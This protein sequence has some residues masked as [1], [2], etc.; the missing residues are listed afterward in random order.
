[1]KDLNNIIKENLQRRVKINENF[2]K[3][4]LEE[5]Q[6]KRFD[7][8]MEYL[9]DLVNEGFDESQFE[10][11]INE[12]FEWFKNMFGF[13]SDTNKPA[14]TQNIGDKVVSTAGSGAFSQFKE[15]VIK[16]LLG[17]LG[18]KGPLASAVA[19]I[20]VET[21][22]VDLI[23]IFK[24]KQG[25]MGSSGKVAGGL[26]EAIVTYLV[27]SGTEK[28]SIAYNFM[29]NSIFEA[30]RNEGYDKKLGQFLC[31]VAFKTKDKI[32]QSIG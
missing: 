30:L 24:S 16:K 32:S 18:F 10:G 6:D 28:D 8:T 4:S 20:L 3:I 31:S 5:D 12:K 13:G 2:E 22:I 9:N 19:T 1:M 17:Y 11:L 26:L 21:N 29:R 15:F 23:N 25:C 7:L 14:T 27:E